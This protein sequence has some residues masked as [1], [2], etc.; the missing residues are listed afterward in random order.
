MAMDDGVVSE[1]PSQYPPST[2]EITRLISVTMPL[3]T[4]V[5]TAKQDTKLDD[6]VVFRGRSWCKLTKRV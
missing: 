1:Q 6:Q 2:S 5:D 3:V 4:D